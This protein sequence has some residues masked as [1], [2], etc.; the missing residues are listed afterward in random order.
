MVPTVWWLFVTRI[1][2]GLSGA[3]VTVAS[4]YIADV[5]PP[6]KRAAAFGM[7]GAM[8]GVGF[9]AGPLIGG[10]LG[11]IDIHYPFYCAAALTL[12]NGLYGWFVLPESLP[13]ERRTVH[14]AKSPFSALAVFARYPLALRLAATLFLVDVAQFALHPTWFL[15]THHRYG[16]KEKDVGWSMFAVGVGAFVVQGGLARRIIPLLGET[17]SVI[18][19]L[20]IAAVAYAGYA[21][22]TEGWM[23][24]VAI[25]VASFAGIAF[26]ACQSMITKSVRADQQGTV[27]GGLTSA[28]SLANIVGPIIGA[29]VFTWSIAPANS[30]V[31]PGTVYF[32]SAGLTV[33]AIVV[34]LVTLR[35]TP[36]PATPT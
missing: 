5:T 23:I 1:V 27:Q 11:S 17:R 6:Q 14:A 21:S 15:Y 24:Y 35:H 10:F 29:S 34:A 26:P 16:W 31:H 13:P 19:G 30:D 33:A 3:S 32:V 28:R 4:A 22:A 9:V 25:G 7:F 12:V 18:V 36:P 20:A 8:M 2:N